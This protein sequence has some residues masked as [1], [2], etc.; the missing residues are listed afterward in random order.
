MTKE[1]D[2]ERGIFYLWEQL[3]CSFGKTA[4]ETRPKVFSLTNILQETLSSLHCPGVSPA[5]N[6]NAANQHVEGAVKLASNGETTRD[7]RWF[8]AVVGQ[9]QE[10]HAATTPSGL[11]LQ[12]FPKEKL[13]RESP[14]LHT[15]HHLS[16]LKTGVSLVLARCSH[17]Q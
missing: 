4:D 2:S 11:Y 8:C 14:D 5:H 1:T 10:H 15:Y 3:K 17:E 16:L 13:F 7:W 9:E 6:L 12:T